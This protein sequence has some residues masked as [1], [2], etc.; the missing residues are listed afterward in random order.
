MGTS[1]S[2]PQWRDDEH[3]RRYLAT[4]QEVPHRR[5][6]EAVL[7]D[8]LAAPVRRVADLGSGDGRV[9][10][11]V[12]AEHPAAG[13]VAL[14]HNDLML[15]RAAERFADNASVSVLRQDLAEPL[16][17]LGSVD[18]VVSA[19]ALHHLSY[20][21]RA[22]ISSEVFEALV[23]GGVF[24]D[25]DLVRST[26][27]TLHDQFIERVPWDRNPDR[28][29]DRHPSLQQRL[30]W[31]TDAGFENVDCLWKWRELA[32]VVGEKP[33]VVEES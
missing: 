5:E 15:Q 29:W 6:G 26:S 33:M 24:A 25:L 1:E 30:A 2:D 8:A 10:A 3:A 4:G 31:L 18:A 14:D 7:V 32:L 27:E 9:L 16:A 12:L 22:A 28:A 13:G 23:P 17:D 19:L 20:D 21:R 11:A